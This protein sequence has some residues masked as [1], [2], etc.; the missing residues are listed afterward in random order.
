MR[1][2]RLLSARRLRQQ[3][4]RAAIAAVAVAAAVSLAVAILITSVSIERS[5]TDFGRSLAGPAP[6]RIVGPTARAGLTAETVAAAEG[7]DGVAA[8][9]PV[10]QAVTLADGV[11]G[12][13]GATP[14]LALGVDCR[15][16]AILG[17]LGC[18]PAALAAAS[19]GDLPFAVGPGL[20]G[21]S[22][23]TVR[24]DT[25]RVALAG[26][27]ELGALAGLNQGRVVVF[28]MGAAQ[29][30]FVQPG[31]VDVAYVVPE[32]GTPVGRLR[33]GL[34]DAVGP[35]IGVLSATD[36]PPETQVVLLTFLPLFVLLGLFGLGTG[37]VLVHNTVALS[38]EERRRQLAIL[39]ALGASR[40]TVVG[41]AVGE[42]AVLGLVGGLLGVAAGIAVARPIVASLSN[43]TEAVAGIV[44]TD[45][46]PASAV[47]IGVVL[48]G[49]VAALA[50]LLPARR[51]LR[52]DVAAELSGRAGVT[53]ARPV[54]LVRRGLLWGGVAVVGGFGCWSSQIDGGI[55]PWQATVGPL[56]FL[57][58]AIAV[59]LMGGALAPLLIG[60]AARAARRTRRA[61]VLLAL[62]DLVRDP[63]RAGVMAV[64][65]TSPIIIGFA[66]DGF[67]SSARAGVEESFGAGSDGVSVSTQE[68]NAGYDGF[69]SP[70]AQAAIAALP[71]VEAS[72]RGVFL[73][74]GADIDDLVG[75][76][77]Y[78][79]TDL[80]GDDV[81]LGTAD[82][83]RL[84]AGE[85]LIGPALARRTGARPGDTVDLPTP[86]GMVSVPV[87]GV[88]EDGGFGGFGVTLDYE[89]L[90][91]LYGQRPPAFM[92]VEPEPG[93]SEGDLAATLIAAAPTI[94]P[95]LQVL[96]TED[97][98]DEITISISA[99]MAPF[100]AMRT[101]LQVVAFVAVLSTLL[102]AGYQRRREHGV[103]AAIGARPPDLGRVVLGQAGIVGVAA[104]VCG[105]VF[106]PLLLWT[107]MQVI[108][109]LVGQRNPFEPDWA[110]L[111]TA[112]VVGVVVAVVAGLWPAWR[113]GRVEVLDALRYE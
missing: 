30:R 77:A 96:T 11:A 71:G 99:Q 32:P 21:Q 29:R 94:D 43:F 67:V 27:P 101:A 105:A 106:G 48:G 3:P 16:E 26:V 46:V 50:A 82:V 92:V 31:L 79:G 112:S 6:L 5:V 4:L 83:E 36:P 38:L 72:Y 81:L 62:A 100:R 56:A 75:V 66:T 103:L 88:L 54:R 73:S 33:A 24:T 86:R 52:A 22:D 44:L 95:E 23:A 39:G 98:I 70:D 91:R 68:I 13:D 63:R 14:V 60:R 78:E 57:V 69:L 9:V 47:L 17:A 59:P 85:V 45:H 20:A 34:A 87:Q 107:M 110:S 65:V 25:G 93:V 2:F 42:A 7:V 51:A 113:A 108:P 64:A 109:I 61:S 8:L 102:L 80:A 15:V 41:G 49:L 58:V 84:R 74:V 89:H 28:E 37:A 1:V 12:S 104:V 19:A 10:V 97:L 53:E 18:D 76:E 40:R 111:V 35:H 55:E 90:G